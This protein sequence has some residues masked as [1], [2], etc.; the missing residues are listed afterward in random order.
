MWNYLIYFY[1]SEHKNQQYHNRI[2]IIPNK[3]WMHLTDLEQL[4]LLLLLLLRF[5]YRCKKK[6]TCTFCLIVAAN[7]ECGNIAGKREAITTWKLPCKQLKSCFTPKKNLKYKFTSEKKLM[8]MLSLF[9]FSGFYIFK[10][11]TCLR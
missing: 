3:N 8:N 10:A 5:Q 11:V 7:L 4:L 2:I 1:L 9:S 6:G